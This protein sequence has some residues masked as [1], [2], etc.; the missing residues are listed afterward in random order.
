MKF[1]KAAGIIC[2]YNPFHNGHIHHIEQTR[3]ITGCDVLVCVMSGN[4]VQ[5]GEPAIIDKWERTRAALTHGV[6]LMIE[7]PFAYATQSAAFFAQGAVK[8]LAL[9]DVKDIVFG[10]E[11]NDLRTLGKLAH[12][13]SSSYRDLM[14]DGLSAAKAYEIIYGKMNP[15]DILGIN[16]IQA[17]EPYGI[18]PHCIQR[19]NEYHDS[20]LN[21]HF[22]SAS[23]LRMALM[24]KQKISAYSPMD[25]SGQPLHTLDE[26][27]PFLQGQLL[28]L[29]QEYLNTLFMM[30][31]GMENQLK[32]HAE[33]Y[34][35][36][37]D[38][39]QA[40]ISK[41][42]SASRI[43][44]TLIHLLHHTT[45]TDINT[46]P[47]LAH[48]R[49]LGFNQK[50]REYLKELKQHQDLLIA[51]RISQLPLPYRKMELKA[52][53]VYGLS[54]RRQEQVEKELQPP[55]RL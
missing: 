7:L 33:K 40:S 4:F 53:Q 52:A 25:V 21:G 8:T 6:D 13:D 36:F 17:M 44:R 10:S 49:I 34:D 3:K 1:M 51:S 23:A 41:R 5:R 18:T 14:E 50:G 24:N 2:E 26:Y 22:A 43:R 54:H 39:L 46:L 29:S 12:L 31:E 47:A 48:I 32:V 27:Y 35:K 42:Y 55:L 16:Y 30:D 9:A 45:K 19:T 37:E 38:F 28:T 15:N 11:S 20:S